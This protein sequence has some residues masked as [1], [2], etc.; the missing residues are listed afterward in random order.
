MRKILFLT[1]QLIYP[2][3]SGGTIASKRNFDSF[4]NNDYEIDL[5]FFSD[6]KTEI[7]VKKFEELYPR[8]HI[9][10]TCNMNN[11]RSLG[12]LI[13]SFI[14]GVPLNVYRNFNKLLKKQVEQYLENNVYDFIYCDHLEMAQYIP[15]AYLSKAMLY[16]H[17]AE[18]MIWKRYSTILKNPV[19]KFGVLLESL[20]FKK[21]ELGICNKVGMVLAAPNDIKIL[22]ENKKRGNFEETY[23]LG[24]DRMLLLPPLTKNKEEIHLLFIGTMSW[25]ANIDAV[26]WFRDK[27]LPLL[28][29]KYPSIIFDVVGKW[30]DENLISQ[31]KNQNIR[32]HGF[33]ESTEPFFQKSLVFVCPLQ[34]GSG[35]KVKNIE[36]L[37]R[38]IPLVTTTI[39]A[40]SI[41]LCD[42]YNSF[43]A[44]DPKSFA[45]C[46]EKLIDSDELWYKLSI[47]SRKLAEQKYTKKD[48][49]FRLLSQINK[50]MAK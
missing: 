23:H 33:V 36:A 16:E 30:K 45:K 41:D 27:V 22:S 11:K 24:D 31:N 29:E 12:N 46:I 13:K 49:E 3:T 9:H 17:N 2:G 47:N 8:V 39:G 32:Y 35:M 14:S 6:E 37:Y 44:D 21:Y 10:T 5:F 26:F 1:T 28:V 7:G 15:Q 18:Y 42:N 50:L 38:G 19:L 48:A 25:Q 43:I 40:E 34:F 20:R 4:Y